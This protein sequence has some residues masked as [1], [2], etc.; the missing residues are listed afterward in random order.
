MENLIIDTRTINNS[1]VMRYSRNSFNRTN[2]ILSISFNWR[3]SSYK[4]SQQPEHNLRYSGHKEALQLS[5]KPPSHSTDTR[6]Y[7]T[8]ICLLFAK[9][10]E[11]ALLQEESQSWSRTLLS[12]S[13]ELNV[14]LTFSIWA[15]LSV[16]VYIY[17]LFLT[18][19]HI[20]VWYRT[21]DPS[22]PRQFFKIYSNH[23]AI[24]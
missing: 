24:Y 3:K 7:N 13:S 21:R 2:W 16:S 12:A 19:F 8:L 10:K 6:W 4:L 1:L 20:W 9:P 11:G 17:P 22:I 18:E 14:S 5:L 23:D 15:N